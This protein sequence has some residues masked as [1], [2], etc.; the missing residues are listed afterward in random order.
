[1]KKELRKEPSL[2]SK[3]RKAKLLA[4]SIRNPY[5]IPPKKLMDAMLKIMCNSGLLKK[6]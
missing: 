6:K 4:C 1:M 5:L 2:A 3:L